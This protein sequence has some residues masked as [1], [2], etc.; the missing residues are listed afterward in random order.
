VR[1]KIRSVAKQVS[2]NSYVCTGSCFEIYLC[3]SPRSPPCPALALHSPVLD[4]NGGE[5]EETPPAGTWCV[6]LIIIVA[7]LVIICCCWGV[8]RLWSGW[9]WQQVRRCGFFHGHFLTTRF[10]GWPCADERWRG[11]RVV[12]AL[13]I[14]SLIRRLAAMLLL[15]CSD[16]GHGVAALSRFE[17]KR[18]KGWPPQFKALSPMR[19][20][21]LCY[22]AAALLLPM[23]APLTFYLSFYPS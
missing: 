8:L 11:T 22:S 2:T 20:V 14:T 18:R 23:I 19:A 9:A 3:G 15:Y 10:Q 5:P 16:G 4:G 13:Y 12:I 17:F 7:L 1:Q 21:K 6:L